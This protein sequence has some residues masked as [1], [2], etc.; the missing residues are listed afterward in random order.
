MQTTVLY[1]LIK[2]NFKQLLKK[3]NLYNQQ[4]HYNYE[5][6]EFFKNTYS[7]LFE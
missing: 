1:N 2:L 7:Y 4:K 5:N 6:N 3:V